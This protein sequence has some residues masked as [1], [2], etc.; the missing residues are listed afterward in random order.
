MSGAPRL[1]EKPAP[2]VG[3][4]LLSSFTRKAADSHD[5]HVFPRAPNTFS[6]DDGQ[7]PTGDFVSFPNRRSF[8]H[9]EFSERSA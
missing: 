3:V 5:H 4:F 9:M 6:L 8:M 1:W 2:L 7:I